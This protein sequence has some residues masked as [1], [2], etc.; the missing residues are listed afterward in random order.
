MPYLTEDVASGKRDKKKK[1]VYYGRAGD[2]VTIIATH[3]EVLI[4][5]G[6]EKFSVHKSK[7]I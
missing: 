6:K 4:V 7:V 5:E 1:L 3:G 2:K